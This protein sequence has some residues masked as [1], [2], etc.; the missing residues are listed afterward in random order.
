MVTLIKKKYIY[1]LV[2]FFF[3]GCLF[4]T[5]Y[6]ELLCIYHLGHIESRRGILFGPFN[7][8]YG[9]GMILIIIFLSRLNK[10]RYIFLFGSILGGSFEYLIWLLQKVIFKHISWN[11]SSFIYFNNKPILNF[12][13]WKGTSL[14]HS[15][16]WGLIS[17]LFI[18]LIY[19]KIIK[20]IDKIYS[21]ILI[22][23]CN[24]FLLFMIINA[25]ISIIAVLRYNYRNDINI[26]NNLFDYLFN[27]KYIEL[28]FP[29]MMPLIQ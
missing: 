24:V 1:E 6:E 27:D 8:V 14:F 5:I 19:K 20:L 29:N 22:H 16:F 18:V 11:Y 15:L 26:T 2:I 28:I 12:L 21:E 13:F 9:L 25:V 17:L 4:G 10:K 3:I 7:P 23:Y